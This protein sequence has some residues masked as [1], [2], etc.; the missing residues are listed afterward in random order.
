[1]KSIRKLFAAGVL[2][3]GGLAAVAGISIASADDAPPPP[4][5]HGWH[6]HGPRGGEGHFFAQLNLSDEQKASIKAIMTAAWPQ[7]KSVHQQMRANELKLHQ[8]APTDPNYAAMVSEVSTADGSLHAQMIT[9]RADIRT[10]VF[11]VLTPT[12][13]AQL[14][15]LEAQR[16]AQHGRGD[17]GPD[18]PPPSL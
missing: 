4:P 18:G 6:H 11:K 13:Q 17:R 15:S 12:Q 14:I 9:Q 1:M 2:A 3:A 16:Q 5:P 7:M 8:T 10:Q